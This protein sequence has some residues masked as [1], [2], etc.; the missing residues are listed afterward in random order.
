M[1]LFTAEAEDTP[2][3]TFAADNLEDAEALAES[4]KEDWAAVGAIPADVSLFVRQANTGEMTLW[5]EM[6]DEAMRNVQVDEE[7]IVTFHVTFEP[8][9]DTGD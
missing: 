9:D 2:I 6:R 1:P 3:C 5:T 7:S 8:N 4:E